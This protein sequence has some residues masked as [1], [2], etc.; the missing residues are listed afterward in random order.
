MPVKT[1]LSVSLAVRIS[2]FDA[3]C[4]V[5]ISKKLD[6]DVSDVVRIAIQDCIATFDTWTN[7]LPAPPISTPKMP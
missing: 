5:S 1:K 3:N 2:E 6:C 7:R 4:L